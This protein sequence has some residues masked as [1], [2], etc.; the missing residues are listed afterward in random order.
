MD[1]ISI[2]RTSINHIV[3]YVP[4]IIKSKIENL[5]LYSAYIYKM[6]STKLESK[7]RVLYYPGAGN[8][9]PDL[10][11]K[12]DK[13]ILA[14]TLPNKGGCICCFSKKFLK[15]KGKAKSDSFFRKLENV[16]F[17]QKGVINENEKTFIL[18]FD[19]APLVYH[20]NTNV[21]LFEVPDEVTD[22]FLSN[23]A[24][25]LKSLKKM[26]KGRTVWLRGWIDGVD[27]AQIEKYPKERTEREEEALLKEILTE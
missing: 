19:G 10:G 12:F 7:K 4:I 14:D 20:Y 26:I 3:G 22:I 24:P 25:S 5:K 18:R 1:A 8:D 9:Q 27:Y 23:Y 11:E 13:Y 16:F 2:L 21:E 17:A 6:S 15:L